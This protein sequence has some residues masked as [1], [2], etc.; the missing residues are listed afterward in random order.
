MDYDFDTWF[1][2]FVDKCRQLNYVGPIDKYSFEWNWED[3]ETPEGAAELFVKEA[4]E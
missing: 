2:L 3:G 1:E 4:A